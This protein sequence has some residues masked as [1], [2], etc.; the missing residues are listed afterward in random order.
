MFLSTIQNQTFGLITSI[1]MDT[2]VE[3]YPQMRILKYMG[4]KRGLLKWLIPILRE[5][6]EPEEIFLDLFAGTSAVGYALKSRNRIIAND[7]Q[8]YSYV[9]SKALLEFNK[10]IEENDFLINLSSAYNKNL[11][12]LTNIYEQAL[13][14]EGAIFSKRSLEEYEKFVN[15]FPEYTNSIEK[16]TFKISDY[17][18][19]VFISNRRKNPQKFP[20]ILFSTYYA[21]TFFSLEQ[22][23]EIDSL[24]YAIDQIFDKSKKAVY[25]SC[26]VFAISRTVNSTG[27]FA[28]Y[29]STKKLQIFDVRLNSVLANFFF[30]LGEFRNLHK[31]N[32]WKNLTLNYDW[33]KAITELS[34]KNILKDVKLIYID[35]PYT[36]AQYSRYY[37]IPETLVK[38]DYPELSIHPRTKKNTKGG[39]RSDRLQSSFSQSTEVENAFTEIFDIISQSTDSILAISYSDNSIIKPVDKLIEIA[40]K[41]YEIVNKENGHNHSAQGSRFNKN[42]KGRRLVNE[43]VLLCKHK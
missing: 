28:E 12:A 25:L 38:Y 40:S 13:R 5:N 10:Q 6:I 35:P 20:Y 4:N 32:K 31:Q 42:N 19:E 7:I 33:K 18:S 17:C 21:N 16:D 41:Y 43:Y 11:K 30:K 9:I 29:L 1:K 39:Y 27:H 24:R 14:S 2:N 22:C 36:T 23:I 37:H 8:E 3:E 26:L 15:S 34:K